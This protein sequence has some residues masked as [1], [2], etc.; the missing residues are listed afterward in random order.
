MQLRKTVLLFTTVAAFVAAP[1][2]G[3]AQD[4]D[5]DEVIEEI[6]TTGT[7]VE[8]TEFETPQTVTQF[9][10]DEVRQFTSSSQADILTQL[11]GVS[12]EGGG[13]EVAT[14]VFHRSLPSG[15]QFSFNPLLYDGIPTFTTFGLNSSAFDVFYRND[16]GIKR[17]EFVSGGVSNLFGPGSVAGII[18]YISKT[19]G[20]ENTGTVQIEAAE[21]GRFK[22]DYFF[23]GPLGDDNS[24]T[25][26]AVSGY[27][28]FDEGPLQSG[29]DTQGFQLRG[30][31]K[32]EFSDGSGSVTL[33]GQAIDDSVQFFLPLPLDGTSRERVAG[34][35]GAEVFTMNTA[36]AIG[37]SYD[38]P[39]G[40]FTTPIR[41]GVLTK[42]T[43]IAVVLDKDLTSDWTMNAKIRYAQY[44]HQFNLFLDG[45]GIGPNTPETQAEY[46]TNRGVDPLVAATAQFTFAE[47]GSALPS[48]Y[49]L[50]GNRTLD[51]WRDAKDFS[52]EIS[53]GRNLTWGDAEHTFTF[54]GFF[55]N[56][57]ADD[58]NYIT[59]YLGDFRNAP[60]LV[61]VTFTGFQEDATGALVAA[62]D[63]NA[64]F[65]WTQNGLANANGMTGNA[66]RSARR[67]AFYVADQIEKDQWSFDFGARVERLDG[68]VKD[69]GR[70]NFTMA[71]DP[72]LNN[73]LEQVS[74]TDGSLRAGTVSA[75]EWAFSAGTL[76]RINDT[77][78]VFAN[79]SRGFFF[80]QIRSV[81]FNNS[82]ELASYEGEIIDAI[83]IG[84]KL[85]TDNFDGY[86]AFFYTTLDDRR[87]V[88]FEND[89]NNPGGV[90]EVVTTQST[91]AKGIE[92]SGT[93]HI[94]DFWSL[95]AN[96][97]LRDSEFTKAEN[98]DVLGKEMRRQP[99][100]M[101]NTGVR[102]QYA[103]F[104]A[105]LMHNYH[106]DNYANDNNSVKLEAYN[107]VRLEAGYT[108]EFDDGQTLRVSGNVFNLTD[109]Q[110]ITEGSPRQ[111]N[112]QS[113][114]P[115]QFFVGRPILPRRVM[116]RVT[117]DF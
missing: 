81:P 34:N 65:Q 55:S 27:Y 23:S 74:F 66:D 63:P 17:T 61:D 78:N 84:A 106:G 87:N 112:A 108:F 40:R 62:G 77:V 29:L 95:N 96:V 26:Y 104:D 44:D 83:E 115:E 97:T 116:L 64:V 28:R 57:Q 49:L 36:E 103:N 109:D 105:S 50:F 94:N 117:Y 14:N 92:A 43:S 47:T 76:Y 58:I 12:A 41:D 53:V 69:F 8:R 39:D 20:P 9:S 18:N 6:I 60:K 93:Y 82:G 45:D 42:G 113:G 37:L 25:F 67:T 31:L 59:T 38:T 15:G 86:V 2:I 107:L 21:E 11:P 91:E 7:A 5:S 10:E 71:N 35:D 68:D 19:G 24:D 30:N 75:T 22:G 80:P 89:P 99:S 1:T 90:I 98:A 79:A 70:S 73:D 52:A 56:S 111:G 51:R 110:G 114:A 13:G 54:G 32:R 16:L 3:F 88:D 100:T 102:F 4:D 48:S 85:Q 72:L 46:L 101:F 33:Y